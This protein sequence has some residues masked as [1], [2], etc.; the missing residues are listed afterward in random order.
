M[1][2]CSADIYCDDWYVLIA[3]QKN[4]GAIFYLNW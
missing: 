2:S 1:T 3:P 4:W